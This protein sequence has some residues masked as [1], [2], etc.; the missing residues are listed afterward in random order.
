MSPDGATSAARSLDSWDVFVSHA[1]ED[2]DAI[3]R[4]LAEEL[5]S[6]GLKVWYD[7]FELKVGDSLSERIDEG[8]ARSHHGI[9]I[10]SQHFFA[11]EWSKKELAG[12]T[13]TEEGQRNRILPVWHKIK[14]QEVAGHSP[15]LADRKAATAE[16]ISAV[17]DELLISMNR[18]AI[19]S[20]AP[21]REGLSLSP[22]PAEVELSLH[23]GGRN[24]LEQISGRHESTTDLSYI[25][26]DELRTEVAGWLDELREL[27]EIWEQLSLAEQE[28]AAKHASELMVFMLEQEVLLQLGTYERRLAGS[29]GQ[30]SPWLGV[31]IRAVPA[32][33][34]SKEQQEAFPV[35][36][37]PNPADQQQLDELLGLV[38]R[39]SIKNLQ[40][41]DFHS[42]WPS[43][44]T[45]PF[46][47][48]AWDYDEVEHA[49]DDPELEAERQRLMQATHDFLHKE[50]MNGYPSRHVPYLRDAGYTAGEAEGLPERERLI[51]PRQQAI[52][53]AAITLA[54]VYDDL[55]RT[56]KGKGY[57]LDAMKVE[58]HPK[59]EE[60]DQRIEK[61]RGER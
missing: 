39:T 19:D 3:A 54:K 4:P 35:P 52:F 42:S 50:A 17:A 43:K 61:I 34:L 11:K 55:V 8:L 47:F 46:K 38:T 26:E 29:D 51:A 59:V 31:L 60:F 9:V 24:V 30:S 56:A 12:L 33:Q 1:S 10:L 49:F 13:A 48:L 40:A 22:P 28:K 32:A 53:E 5:R 37:K 57:N 14:K 18:E 16:D 58:L 36:S 7:E 23:I 6:R 2:K 45:T 15:M 20:D 44:V 41:Q 27:G 25:P 21:R